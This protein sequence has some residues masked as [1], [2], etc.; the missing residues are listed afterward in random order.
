[1]HKLTASIFFLIL[2][3]KENIYL[4]LHA[5]VKM[6]ISIFDA[7]IFGIPWTMTKFRTKINA[8]EF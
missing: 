8:E 2:E 1:M 3:I 7:Y 6:D 4:A 5:Y